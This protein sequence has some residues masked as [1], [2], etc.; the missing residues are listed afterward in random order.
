MRTLLFIAGLALC[1]SG[2][3]GLDRAFCAPACRSQLHNASSLVSF[4][5]P[6]GSPPP[7]E[8]VVPELRVPL[9]VGLAFL[10]P[11]GG[12]ASL[13]LDAAR[14]QALLERIRERFVTRKF[15][16]EI[17]IIPDYYLETSRGFAG[18]EGLQR[19]YDVDLVA[20]VSYDQVTYSSDTKGSLA[21]LTIIGAYFV[22]ATANDTSTLVDLAVVDPR[23]RSLVLRAGGSDTQ[24]HLNTLVDSPRAVRGAS[25]AGF[26]AATA[27]MIDHFDTALSAFE[28]EVHAGT[29]RVHVSARS[30]GGG[31]GACSVWDL[32]A[33]VMLVLVVRMRRRRAGTLAGGGRDA[34]VGA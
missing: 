7:R 2:C 29:A 17:V 21:Y 24:H 10:P 5:Y 9:R 1:S 33:A 31:G 6:N 15:V 23:T 18:L 14:K 25:G 34:E 4:L 32:L 30:G 28:Q 13:E 8:D 27:R 3:A 20:L 16:S 12:A 19:L 22:P 11:Q 26:E